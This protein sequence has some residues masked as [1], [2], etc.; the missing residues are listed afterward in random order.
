MTRLELPPMPNEDASI[1]GLWDCH[2]V[3]PKDSWSVP[4]PSVVL[5]E[6]WLIDVVPA[7]VGTVGVGLLAASMLGTGSARPGPVAAESTRY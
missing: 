7:T 2:T 3:T 4:G 6:H 5:T 1:R